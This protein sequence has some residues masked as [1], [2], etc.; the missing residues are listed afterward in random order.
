MNEHRN[1]AEGIEQIMVS[2]NRH[3]GP[4]QMVGNFGPCQMVG[5]FGPCQM[6]AIGDPA[7]M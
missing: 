2:R 7:T 4:C 5:N 6:V 1:G 3:F